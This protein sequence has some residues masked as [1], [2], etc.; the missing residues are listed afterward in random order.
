MMVMSTSRSRTERT[1]LNVRV[2]AATVERLRQESEAVDLS[3]SRIVQAALDEYLND[4][5]T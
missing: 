5:P 3:M 4:E 2:P 1:Q